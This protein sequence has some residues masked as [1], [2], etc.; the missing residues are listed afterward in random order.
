MCILCSG[1]HK[2][3]KCDKFCSMPA[4]QRHTFVVSNKRCISCLNTHEG[5]CRMK[6]F[7]KGCKRHS[8]HNS[9][10]HDAVIHDKEES[11][12]SDNKSN[13]AS[14]CGLS[15]CHTTNVE[16]TVFAFHLTG[17]TS[18]I[19]P[20][21][22]SHKC[23]PEH[24]ILTYAMLDSQSVFTFVTDDLADKVTKPFTSATIGLSTMTSTNVPVHCNVYSD[25][26]VRGF[27]QSERVSL[28]FSRGC[29]SIPNDLQVPT[30][31]T[32]S[33]TAE[34]QNSRTK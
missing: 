30:A 20:V 1:N 19:V 4:K 29:E 21:Y 33:R 14:V 2:L 24:E 23:K 5:K 22:L 25:L 17:S 12:Q 3:Y 11:I 32:K 34:Q 8:D 15:M 18:M 7:C 6:I 26:V 13:V 10:L 9:L 31:S 16:S 27:N 28:K